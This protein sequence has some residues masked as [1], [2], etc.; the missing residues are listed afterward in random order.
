MNLNDYV[1]ACLPENEK[2][3]KPFIINED[4]TNHIKNKVVESMSDTIASALPLTPSP[5]PYE[6][7]KD[8]YYIIQHMENN[9]F[10]YS[11]TKDPVQYTMYSVDPEAKGFYKVFKSDKSK[12]NKKYSTFKIRDRQKAKELYDELAK[13]ESSNSKTFFAGDTSNDYIYQRLTE[14]SKIISDDQIIYDTRFEEVKNFNE[15]VQDICESVRNFILGDPITRLEEQVSTLSNLVNINESS[16]YV[17]SD[18]DMITSIEDY[19]NGYLK[20]YKSYLV[21]VDNQDNEQI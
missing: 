17:S 15:E 2:M 7:D 3:I 11:L 19:D 18:Y 14:G 6:C 16:N 20:F 21:K 10:A 5:I 8:N 9:A 4:N 13:I 12:I 1:N